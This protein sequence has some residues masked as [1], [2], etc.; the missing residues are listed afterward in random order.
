MVIAKSERYEIPSRIAVIRN[1]GNISY[2][3]KIKN[4]NGKTKPAKANFHPLFL[5]LLLPLV[6]SIPVIAMVN[7]AIPKIS[8][9]QI[10]KLL[11]DLCNVI[12][13]PSKGTFLLYSKTAVPVSILASKMMLSL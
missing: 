3:N 2:G 9:Y 1:N 6:I 7:M 13:C 11:V 12:V 5:K 8:E 4:S 10:Q